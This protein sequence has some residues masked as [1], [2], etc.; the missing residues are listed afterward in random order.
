MQLLAPTSV[1]GRSDVRQAAGL[2]PYV[3]LYHN[4]MNNIC[5]RPLLVWEKGSKK[6]T[7]S[8]IKRKSY[9]FTYVHTCMCVNVYVPCTQQ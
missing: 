2:L 1:S 3:N 4:M 5:Y 9:V 8:G 6:K 7:P